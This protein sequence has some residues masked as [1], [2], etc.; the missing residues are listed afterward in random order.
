M[1]LALSALMKYLSSDMTDRMTIGARIRAARTT[2]GLSQTALGEA[3][4]LSLP[5]IYR[6]EKG[7]TDPSLD[8][9]TKV[10]GALGLTLMDLI[11]GEAA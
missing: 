7:L 9:L 6:L 10:A 1:N 11:N 3:A 5:T 4:G 8:N 2:A